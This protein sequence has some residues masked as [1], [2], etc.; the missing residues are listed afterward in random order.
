MAD[1]GFAVAIQ[2]GGGF[3]EDEDGAAAQGDARDGQA[4][5]LAAGEG[6]AAFADLGVVAVGLRHD[7]VVRVGEFG[8]GDGFAFADGASGGAGEVVADAGR[9]E[10][11]VLWQEADLCAQAG[12]L[13][14]AD[15]VPVDF[16]AA[17]LWLVEA[18]E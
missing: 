5:A 3:V 11:R 14:A 4:L 16:D 1:D 13:E 10:E 2:A 8:G 6:R 15:V 7:E 17:L 9:K 18:Q 12:E